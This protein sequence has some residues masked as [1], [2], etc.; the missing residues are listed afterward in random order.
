M[1][2]QALP[3]H[4]SLREYGRGVAG[5]LI[6]SLPLIYTMEVWW[7]GFIVQPDRL[8]LYVLGSFVLLLGYNRYAGLREDAG[9][10]VA[11]LASATLLWFFG[12]FDGVSLVTGVG[13]EVETAELSIAFLPRRSTRNGWVTFTTDPA[14][15]ERIESH[16]LGYQE[17]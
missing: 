5:G 14:T 9:W 11:L 2:S 4:R 17:P 10:S 1:T 7:T 15:V 3:V 6:L 8:L 16:V 13:E 12:R